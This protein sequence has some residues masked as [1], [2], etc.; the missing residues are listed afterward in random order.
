MGNLSLLNNPI[1]P[2]ILALADALKP[3]SSSDGVFNDLEAAQTV[4]QKYPHCVCCDGNLYVFDDK[5]GL[6]TESEEVT[7]NIISRFDEFL[8][9]MK[10]N[11]E[12]RKK[13]SRGLLSSQTASSGEGARWKNALNLERKYHNAMPGMLDCPR[14]AWSA[15]SNMNTSGLRDGACREKI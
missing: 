12:W 3:V 7:F 15:L 14:A 13:S 10:I 2:A 4:Y 6:W 1:S 5:S 9:L 8:Y 11:K